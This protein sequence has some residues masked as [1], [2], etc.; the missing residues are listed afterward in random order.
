MTITGSRKQEDK[1][2]DLGKTAKK[3]FPEISIVS[4]EKT[5]RQS[6]ETALEKHQ[7]QQWSDVTSQQP[8]ARKDFF[9]SI[10]SISKG[11]LKENGLNEDQIDSL[12]K[13][14]EKRNRRYLG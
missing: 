5:F 7:Y 2:R 12:I 14:L 1:I 4:F 3:L 11:T 6:I 10:L 9:E 13:K 8:V